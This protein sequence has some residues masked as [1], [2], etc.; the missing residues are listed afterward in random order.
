VRFT[1][2]ERDDGAVIALVVFGDVDLATVPDFR[3]FL[4]DVCR[5]GRPVIVDLGGCTFLDSVGVGLLLGA[6]RRA[7]AGLTVVGAGGAVRSLLSV[8]G[9]DQLVTVRDLDA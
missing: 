5:D 2:Q 4:S 7:G 6:A 3:A 9:F 8:T 1:V